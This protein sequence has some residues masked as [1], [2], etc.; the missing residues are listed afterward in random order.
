MISYSS[1]NLILR[2]H[3]LYK[4]LLNNDV[5][6]ENDDDIDVANHV[7]NF[8]MLLC[9]IQVLSTFFTKYLAVVSELFFLFQFI[10]LIFSF[11]IITKVYQMILIEKTKKCETNFFLNFPK[12]MIKKLKNKKKTERNKL[13]FYSKV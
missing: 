3:S 1:K 13:V 4:E 11:Q 6:I 2:R 5:I 7:Q 8:M 9:V 10:K 12:N